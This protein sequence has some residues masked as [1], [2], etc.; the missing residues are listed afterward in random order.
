[1]PV[2]VVVVVVVTQ[3]A[4]LLEDWEEGVMVEHD[5]QS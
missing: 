4:L 2:V 3:T 1:L 5:S